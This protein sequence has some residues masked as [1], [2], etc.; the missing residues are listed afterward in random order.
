[1]LPCRQPARGAAARSASLEYKNLQKSSV[2]LV[3]LKFVEDNAVGLVDLDLLAV[4]YQKSLIQI[5]C[6]ES[7][8]VR[9]VVERDKMPVVG[10]QRRILGYSPLIG[11][12]S[13]L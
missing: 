13:T 1:M 3:T 9:L 12:Q 10:E 7:H 11:R 4:H 8:R 2:E 5:N 6:E